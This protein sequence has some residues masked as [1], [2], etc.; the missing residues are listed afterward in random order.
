MSSPE[1]R[2]AIDRLR[3]RHGDKFV[4]P[5]ATWEQREYFRNI[6]VEVVSPS[7]YRRRGR[8]G[9]TSGWAP[10]LMLLPQAN[11][12]GSSDLLTDK[13]IIVAWINNGKP[14]YVEHD[15]LQVAVYTGE[16]R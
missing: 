7:G 14:V 4:E 5:L 13:D 16:A 1:Y 10:S 8:I 9:I 12:S 11:S 15:R 3:A 6:R 2:Q